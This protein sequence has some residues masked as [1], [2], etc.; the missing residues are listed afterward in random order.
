MKDKSLKKLMKYLI[1]DSWKGIII[2]NAILLASCILF[3]FFVFIVNQ[4]K[5]NQ[6]LSL[7]LITSVELTI[8]L[9]LL[10]AVGLL[11]YNIFKTMNQKLFTSEGYL[12]FTMP[13]SVDNL[14]IS[15]LLVNLMWIAFTG[16]VSFLGLFLF[17]TISYSKE[18]VQNGNFFFELISDIASGIEPIMLI[19]IFVE[20]ILHVTFY[21]ITLLFLITFISL[22]DVIL[23]NS[24]G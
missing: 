7:I 12:T 2:V 17:V 8:I 13:V 21:L 19:N 23:P 22:I 4:S 3:G 20:G 14:L 15:R 18:I 10:A 1:I 9:I 24:D 6:P 11:I 16:I 5:F